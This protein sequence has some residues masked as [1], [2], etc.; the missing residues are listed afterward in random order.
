MPISVVE[1]T[2]QRFPS[3]PHALDVVSGRRER[4]ETFEACFCLPE[5]VPATRAASEVNFPSG[6]AAGPGCVFDQSSRVVTFPDSQYR[7]FPNIRFV[8]LHRSARISVDRS[9][10]VPVPPNKAL[11]PTPGSVTPRATAGDAK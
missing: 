9:T 10:P 2:S 11:E 4:P 5:R 6:V 1:R 8:S 7:S 3:T